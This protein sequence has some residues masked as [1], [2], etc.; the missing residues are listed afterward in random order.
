MDAPPTDSR[1][2]AP[3]RDSSMADS[4]AMDSAPPDTSPPDTSPPD[5]SPPDTGPPD[6]GCPDGDSDGV[7]DSMDV[8]PGS[9]DALDEDGDGTPDGC[10]PCAIDGPL[11]TPIPAT[12]TNTDITISGVSLGGG[13]NVAVVNGGDSLSVSLRYEIVDCGCSGCID[14]IEIGLVPDMSFQYCAYSAVPGCGGDTGSDT[15]TLVVPPTPGIYYVRFG[16]GQ[17]FGCTH[18]NWWQGSPPA[19]RTIGAL[20]VR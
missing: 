3:L 19:G 16:R 6:T 8:C 13:G 9:D 18:T 1:T 11:A 12:V 10:D 7:C 15:G 14:Q 17:N 5:T 2:D 20:C 4:M